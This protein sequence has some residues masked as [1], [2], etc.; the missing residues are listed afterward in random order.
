[1][2]WKENLITLY[3]YICQS[4]AIKN[5]LQII[6]QS[7]NCELDFTDEEAM[8]VYIFG[9]MQ[10]YRKVK[11]IHLFTENFL[12]GWFPKLP[13]YS[14]F[15]NRLNTI[16]LGFEVMV[17]EL[18]QEEKG[19][20]IFDKESLIDSLPIIVAGNSRSSSAKVAKEICNKGY[21]SSKGMYYYGLKLHLMGCVRPSTIPLP[22]HCWFTSAGEN[23]LTAARPLL[24]RQQ[25]RKIYADKIY[26]DHA[27]NEQLISKQN[28]II[29]TP[30]K[31][32]KGQI[33]MDAADDLFS[34]AVSRV[35]QPIE[36]F[37][38]WL[39]EKTG[40]QNANKV[41]SKNGLLAHGWGRLASACCLICLF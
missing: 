25:N 29:I 23:D 16:A 8:T 6:R 9:I 7:N 40:I 3:L 31:K 39:I 27:L 22:E 5:Y 34:T 26:I 20:L 4:K 35:R 33:L 10:Q 14:A 24:E 12:K 2:E 36:S 19:R 21:C 41:R 37:F 13:S 11:D 38:N 28:C 32:D 17:S 18:L 30:I 1:M 15:N